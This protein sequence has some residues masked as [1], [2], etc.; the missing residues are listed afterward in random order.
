MTRKNIKLAWDINQAKV[1]INNVNILVS[2]EKLAPV[3]T[4]AV[5]EEQDTA[6]VLSK[7]K[8]I[9][10]TETKPGWFLANKLESQ[11]LIEPGSVIKRNAKTLKLM[12]IVHDFDMEPSW[13]AEWIAQAL[14]NILEIS[15]INKLSSIQLPVLGAQH[16]RFETNKFLELL[17]TAL[18]TY[19]GP[20]ETIWL[21]ISHKE[22][23]QALSF[24]KKLGKNEN[25]NA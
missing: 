17:V 16:G 8:K 2:P 1:K 23:P 7:P 10:D 24:L 3:N 4:S 5:V 15:I 19:Q 6:L 11:P 14:D 22:C 21:I 9:T 25:K 12:A 18:K 20:L 13:R